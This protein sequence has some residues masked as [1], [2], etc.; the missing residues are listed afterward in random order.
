MNPAEVH[1]CTSVGREASNVHDVAVATDS[2]G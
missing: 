1:R 2:R